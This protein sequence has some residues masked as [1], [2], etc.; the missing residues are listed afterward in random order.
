MN[1]WT[2]DLTEKLRDE[3]RTH[4]D[5]IA[6]LKKAEMNPHMFMHAGTT[7]EYMRMFEQ[8]YNHKKRKHTRFF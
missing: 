5:S 1:I 6:R 7:Q 2:S 3:I 8:V 4:S